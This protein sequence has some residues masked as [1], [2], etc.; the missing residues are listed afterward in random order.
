MTATA[1][2]KASYKKLA[3]LGHRQLEVHKAI[4][5]LGIASNR[6]IA[7]HLNKPANE[8]TPRV[9]EL[10]E[11]GFVAE[12]GKKWDAETNR[13]VTTW[14]VTDPYAQ[15]QIDLVRDPIEE[16]KLDKWQDDKPAPQYAAVSWLNDDECAA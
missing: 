2:S 11:Y 13:H 1:T 8:I 12:H 4:G 7:K 14:C 9:F 15:K 3:D 10:R 5:E 6:D 16:I